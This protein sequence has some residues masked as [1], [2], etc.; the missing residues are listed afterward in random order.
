MPASAYSTVTVWPLAG[1]NVTANVSVDV[2][3]DAPSATLGDEIDS[4]G[5]PSSSVI[6]PVPVP[7]VLDTVALVGL[8]SATSTVSSDSASSSP[9]TDTS[10]VCSV[11]PAANVSVPGDS[12]V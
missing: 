4:D 8:L 7:A 1:R 12:A 5:A 10:I 9:R 2:S 3:P 11:S 6:V